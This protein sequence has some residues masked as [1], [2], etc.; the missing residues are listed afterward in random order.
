[1]GDTLLYNPAVKRDYFNKYHM[2]RSKDICG[3][4]QDRL[5]TAV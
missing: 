5:V 4:P 1:M 2:F 3:W